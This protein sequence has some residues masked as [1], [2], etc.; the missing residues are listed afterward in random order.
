MGISFPKSADFLGGSFSIFQRHKEYI[1]TA[2]GE[3][4][5]SSE[6]AL[7]TLCKEL[8]YAK[9]NAGDTPVFG[10]RFFNQFLFYCSDPV[11][12]QDMFTT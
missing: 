9:Y 5:S 6:F 1:P 12:I 2:E 3:A 7:D 10:M 8:G 4:V 11:A